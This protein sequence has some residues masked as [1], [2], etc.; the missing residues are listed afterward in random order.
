MSG[1][2][3]IREQKNIA[4]REKTSGKTFFL[5]LIQDVGTR[6]GRTAASAGLGVNKLHEKTTQGD[7]S[8]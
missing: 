5:R 7:F 3:Q 4:I 8:I 1:K 2:N 6:A